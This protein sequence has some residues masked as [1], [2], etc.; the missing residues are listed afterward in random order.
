MTAACRPPG[1][2]GTFIRR[3]GLKHPLQL[4]RNYPLKR[5][6]EHGGVVDTDIDIDFERAP[7]PVTAAS[8]ALPSIS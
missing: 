1:E 2:T 4:G 8:S 6:F 3:V 5:V 7:P